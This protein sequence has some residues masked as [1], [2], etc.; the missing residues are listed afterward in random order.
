MG[1]CVGII[2]EFE[3]G[4]GIIVGFEVGS[5]VGMVI[6]TSAEALLFWES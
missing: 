5:G 2:V 3:V 1:N 6:L 4:S